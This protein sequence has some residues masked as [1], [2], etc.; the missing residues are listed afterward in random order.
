[1]RRLVLRRIAKQEF[2]EAIN[3]YEEQQP[4]LGLRF[5]KAIGQQF[6][7]ILKNP[8]SFPK[9]KH[10]SRRAVLNDF[11]Y[12]IYFLIKTEEIVVV[13]VFHASATRDKLRPAHSLPFSEPRQLLVLD[14]STQ[15]RNRPLDCRF[16]W[17]RF[18]PGAPP[19]SQSCSCSLLLLTHA[20]PHVFLN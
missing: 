12:S 18:P 3:W 6:R 16:M 4:K 8:E 20:P 14:Y 1:M 11:P 9:S 10:G 5:A 7:L 15:Q 13:A 2:Y 17:T 19:S